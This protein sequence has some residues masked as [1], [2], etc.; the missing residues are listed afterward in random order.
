MARS[1]VTGYGAAAS[2][3][4]PAAAGRSQV[5]LPARLAPA[6]AGLSL[7]AVAVMAAHA[8][9]HAGSEPHFGLLAQAL[10]HGRLDLLSPVYDTAIYQGRVYLPLGPLPAVLM[11]PAVALRG[12]GA[13][14]LIITLPA[15]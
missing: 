10:W 2:R 12:P 14:V 9:S 8:W 4:A 3:A 5:G 6:I 13:P 1:V 11:M 15:A 7:I